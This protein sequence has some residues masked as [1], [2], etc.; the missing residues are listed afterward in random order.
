MFRIAF[1]ER[2]RRL[3][4]TLEP[5]KTIKTIGE[6]F[7]NRGSP[8]SEKDIQELRFL[9]RFGSIVGAPGILWRLWDRAGLDFGRP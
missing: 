5:Q 2:F 6:L 3:P 1:C 4:T 9:V 8:D 7:K